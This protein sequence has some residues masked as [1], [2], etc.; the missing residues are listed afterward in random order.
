MLNGN[1]SQVQTIFIRKNAFTYPPLT[2]TKADATGFGGYDRYHSA[3]AAERM[4]AD[5]WSKR[6]CRK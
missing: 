5:V 3:S 2:V 4:L 6:Y 1:V